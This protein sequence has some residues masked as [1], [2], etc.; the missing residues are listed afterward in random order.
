MEGSSHYRGDGVLYYLEQAH[1]LDRFS[2][3]NCRQYLLPVNLLTY[4]LFRTQVKIGQ[5]RG[6]ALDATIANILRM[7]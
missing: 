2:H 3:S 1:L 6:Y 5:A 4:Y 7:E